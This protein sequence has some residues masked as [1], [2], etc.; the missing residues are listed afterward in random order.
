M[1]SDDEV[2]RVVSAKESGGQEIT[3]TKAKPKNDTVTVTESSSISGESVAVRTGGSGGSKTIRKTYD[4]P[5]TTRTYQKS[6]SEIPTMDKIPPGVKELSGGRIEYLGAIYDKETFVA[7][8]AAGQTLGVYDAAQKQELE[9]QYAKAQ[10]AGEFVLVEERKYPVYKDENAFLYAPIEFFPGDAYEDTGVKP[11][12]TTKVSVAEMY[13]EGP[14]VMTILPGGEPIADIIEREAKEAGRET[15]REGGKLITRKPIYKLYEAEVEETLG[16]VTYKGGVAGPGFQ[17]GGMYAPIESFFGE[18]S[19]VVVK[20]LSTPEGMFGELRS[21]GSLEIADVFIVSGGKKTALKPTITTYETATGTITKEEYTLPIFGDDGRAALKEKAPKLYAELYPQQIVDAQGNVIGYTDTPLSTKLNEQITGARTVTGRTLTPLEA[22]MEDEVRRA[23]NIPFLKPLADVGREIGEELYVAS[24]TVEFPYY[25]QKALKGSAP[26]IQVASEPWAIGLMGTAIQGGAEFTLGAG[27]ATAQIL[28]TGVA[29]QKEFQEE[30]APLNVGKTVSQGRLPTRT[31]GEVAIMGAGVG[32]GLGVGA[33]SYA[34]LVGSTALSGNL[35]TAGL[36]VAEPVAYL[37]GGLV[38]STAAI[39][40]GARAVTR[41]AQLA[42]EFGAGRYAFEIGEY[43]AISEAPPILS[44]GIVFQEEGGVA[45][46]I[47]KLTA[48]ETKFISEEFFGM[49]ARVYEQRSAAVLSQEFSEGAIARRSIVVPEGAESFED[50]LLILEERGGTR[51]IKKS[52]LEI[53]EII[54]AEIDTLHAR[55]LL[56]KSP[57]LQETAVELGMFKELETVAWDEFFAEAGMA[58]LERGA[59]TTTATELIELRGPILTGEGMLGEDLFVTSQP[60]RRFLTTATSQEV[61]ENLLFSVGETVDIEGIQAA[62]FVSIYERVGVPKSPSGEIGSISG[63]GV[64]G[65]TMV[66]GG[67]AQATK[68][69]QAPFTP[70]PTIMKA[71]T[72]P[73][74]LVVPS[75]GVSIPGLG[76]VVSPSG[77]Y[78]RASYDVAYTAPPVAPIVEVSRSTLT[79]VQAF[80][81]SLAPNVVVVS[82]S[83]MRGTQEELLKIKVLQGT[84][85]ITEE[86]QRL[87]GVQITNLPPISEPIQQPKTISG[88]T[89]ALSPAWATGQRQ[90]TGIV[91]SQI[92]PTLQLTAPMEITQAAT[93]TPFPPGFGVS[94]T[95]L[96]PP[97]NIPIIPPL[98]DFRDIP[99]RIGKGKPVFQAPKYKPSLIGLGAVPGLPGFSIGKAPKFVTGGE[100]RGILEPKKGKKRKKK[101]K[102]WWFA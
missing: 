91:S 55:T 31:A 1:A 12:G 99:R 37:T 9:Y 50:V 67:M 73:S 62:R 24:H 3:I 15:K 74:R 21:P 11:V 38:I 25:T 76:Q 78:A 93:P 60:A 82:K 2:V 43:R 87:V 97:P 46:A 4:G 80:E 19:T 84:N 92:Q 98:F 14:D 17:E 90:P 39:G 68:A 51:V 45:K 83:G 56:S 77:S 79:P 27:Y 71:I 54:G 101:E 42:E 85:I 49:Q 95:E 23:E 70:T 36:M 10:A 100:I 88:L 26:F 52:P 44:K 75:K 69:L 35:G 47:G 57:G 53:Q 13:L 20:G 29:I 102:L 5:T 7:M 94:I 30:F 6:L 61:A 59:F 48:R 18:T 65:E 28:G 64:G 40:T 58:S 34:S 16:D 86:D 89:S 33:A 96:P 22:S 66:E 81:G 72:K 32:I 63:I 8:R 41:G